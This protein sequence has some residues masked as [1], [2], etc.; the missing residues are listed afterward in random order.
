MFRRY[1]SMAALL[2]NSEKMGEE[3]IKIGKLP[4]L[5]NTESRFAFIT[6]SIDSQIPDFKFYVERLKELSKKEQKSS[7]KKGLTNFK[8]S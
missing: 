1:I 6:N 2:F 7:T 8:T 4:H 3:E 5:A